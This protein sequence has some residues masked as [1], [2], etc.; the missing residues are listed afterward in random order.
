M[1][2][3]RHVRT[4]A[5]VVRTGSYA[6]AARSLGYTQPA[7]SQQMKVLERAVG[8]P[9]FVRVGRGLKLTDAGDVL[10]TH[11]E[12]ILGSIAAAHEQMKAITRLRA[13]RIRICGFPS[14]NATLLPAA[15]ARITEDHPGV[16][17]ELLEEEPPLSLTALARGDCDIA[18]AFSY[19]D[20]EDNEG[21]GGNGGN[22]D[23]GHNAERQQGGGDL[24]EVPLLDDPLMLLM[25]ADH[26]LAR[27]RTVELREF[28]DERWIAGCNRCRGHFVA[29]CADAGFEPDIAF[30]TDDNLAVQGLVAAGTGVALM[31]GMVL[32]FMCHPKVAGRPVVPADHRRVSAF[33]PA[34]HQKVPATRLMLEALQEAAG[35]LRPLKPRRARR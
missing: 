8:T 35:E 24:I 3:S 19:E 21:N 34:G 17:V 10:A 7:I 13:G 22:G 20:S 4:F 5:E 30:T 27:R 15:V 12:G 23:N 2:D 26:P 6:A 32:S 31:P 25:P 1:F 11:A 28:A 33:T 16:R 9:L 14:A 29:A 18:L